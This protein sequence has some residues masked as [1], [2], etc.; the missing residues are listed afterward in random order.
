M[1][2]VVKAV[3]LVAAVGAGFG[4]GVL[5]SASGGQ[6]ARRSSPGDSP[7]VVTFSG[8]ALSMAEVSAR[9]KDAGYLTR[10]TL[11][12]PE[13]LRKQLVDDARL[14][15]MADRALEKGYHLEDA[16]VRGQRQ[17]LAELYR[18]R[19]LDP[20]FAAIAV[21]DAD[22]ASY[23]EQ[24]RKEWQREETLQVA[25]I[26]LKWPT[27]QARRA[28]LSKEARALLEQVRRDVKKDVYAFGRIAEQRSDD[29]DSARNGG[30][31]PSLT[32]AA[33]AQRFGP[34]VATA[35][36]SL[37]PGEVFPSPVE[38]PGGLHLIRLVS[39]SQGFEPTLEAMRERI[40]QRLTS[41]RRRT[42]AEQ[43]LTDVD[44]SAAISIDDKAL[45]ALASEIAQRRDTPSRAA[46]ATT[47]AP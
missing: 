41:E 6:F 4:G 45:A 33:L 44:A 14:E 25:H 15:V 35:A 20:R 19:E 23:F 1:R 12:R 7:A 46:T 29:R 9:L 17:Q 28:A 11:S 24:H 16:F 32:Q 21:T 2:T 26:L 34:A 42:A 8:G 40:K 5:A 30:R 22:V 47:T 39:R 31:H 13:A 36:A 3:I 37:A 27:D 43:L 18:Q 10:Q 38:G